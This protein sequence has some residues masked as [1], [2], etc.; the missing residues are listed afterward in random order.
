MCKTLRSGLLLEIE[1]SKKCKHLWRKAHVQ[2]KIVQNISGL[3]CLLKLRCRQSAHCCGAKHISKS[4]C[5]KHLRSGLLLEVE[6]SKKCTPLWRE[7]RVQVKMCKTPGLARFLKC[8]SLWR[9]EHVLVKMWQEPQ[10]WPA[11]GSWD[12]EKV[13]GVGARSAFGSQKC[14]KLRALSL[15]WCSDLVFEKSRRIDR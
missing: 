13:H 12:V 7:A 14:K 4:Q 3:A 1:M 2:V 11:F 15:L 9:E 6:M 10:V 5:G 8:T